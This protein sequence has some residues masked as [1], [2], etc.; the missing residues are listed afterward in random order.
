M[1]KPSDLVQGTLDMLLLKILTLEPM[2]GFAVSQRL[3]EGNDIQEPAPPTIHRDPVPKAFIGSQHA[4][5]T[6]IAPDAVAGVPIE[7]VM[8]MNEQIDASIAPERL[9]DTRSGWFGALLAA[10]GLH[11]LLAYIVTRRTHEIGVHMTPGA[12]RSDVMC[13]VLNDA[14]WMVCAGLA[15]GAPQ[16]F[17]A[18]S[19]AASLICGLPA[20][21]PV[22][23]VF[24]RAVIVMLGLVAA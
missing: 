18:K 5:R 17:R 19:V 24:G 14:L 21:R 20:N 3:K 22:S 1:N 16:A 7:R 8:T 4:V 6:T 23:I 15:L 9:V 10:I 11:G 12:T 13:V 2:I